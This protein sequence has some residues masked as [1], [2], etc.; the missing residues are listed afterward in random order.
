[1][2]TLQELKD[3][4]DALDALRAR[5]KLEREAQEQEQKASQRLAQPAARPY[6]I[7]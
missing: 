3:I 4:E 1:M 2:L 6:R 5:I 7:P